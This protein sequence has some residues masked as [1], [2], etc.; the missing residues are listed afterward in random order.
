MFGVFITK[1]YRKGKKII[2]T[3]IRL[4]YNEENNDLRKNIEKYGIYSIWDSGFYQT[5]KQFV[6]S[7]DDYNNNKRKEDRIA[8]IV[9]TNTLLMNIFGQT[10]DITLNQLILLKVINEKTLDESIISTYK[11]IKRNSVDVENNVIYGQMRD[12]DLIIDDNLYN[13]IALFLNE[14]DELIF[15]R[16]YSID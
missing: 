9:I 16:V 15:V 1:S 12:Y 5:E 10:E 8:K 14:K 7:I 4:F 3:D 6:F 13:N 2:M 11:R